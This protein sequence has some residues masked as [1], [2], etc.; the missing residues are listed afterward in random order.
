MS[1]VKINTATLCKY[2]LMSQYLRPLQLARFSESQP[3]TTLNEVLVC[4]KCLYGD[5]DIRDTKMYT[6]PD[7]FTKINWKAKLFIE[8]K[9]LI[10]L[11]HV[12]YF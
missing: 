8:K 4:N 5:K 10:L 11:K 6:I 12:L 9:P 3:C 2:W 1:V 7:L